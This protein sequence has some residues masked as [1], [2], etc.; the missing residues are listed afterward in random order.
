MDLI[1]NLALGF[2][3]SL[4][5]ENILYAFVGCT[6]GTLIGVLPGIGALATIAM[7]LPVTFGL[8][9][10]SG[11]IMLAGIYYG[12][13]YGGSISAILVNLPGETS[14]VVTTID[15]HQMARRGQAGPALAAAALASFFAGTV[16]T[17]V[18]A[19]FAAPLASIAFEFGPA[20][21]F[22]LMVVGLIGAVVLA[23]GPLLKA[24]A[25]IVLGLLLGLVGTD[26]NTGVA[27]FDMRIPE[28][29]EGLDVVALA[30]GL[31]AIP[32]IIVNLE[33]REVRESI[34]VRLRNLWPS[35]TQ[36]R[37][38]VP[39]VLRGTTLGSLLGILP[40]GAASVA[41]FASYTLEK[42]T[43]RYREEFGKGAIEGV[44]GPEAANNAAAQTTFIPL[45][46]L[47]LP[48]NAVMALMMGAMI[49]HNI[50]PSPLVMTKEPALFWGLI[51]SMW[52]GNLILVILNLPLVGVWVQLLK[53]QYKYL[54]PAI[55]VFCCIG[56]Y[57]VGTTSFDIYQT[58][59][60]GV[61][62]YVLLKLGC[63]PAPLLLGFVL[64][65][66][67]EESFRRALLISRGNYVT[68]V[69]SPIS[70]AL[71]AIAAVLALTVAL[72]AIKRV[73]KTAFS[74]E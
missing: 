53:V 70:L 73:R 56:A 20:E 62:G 48:S 35:G 52:V 29:A 59:V 44:A 16:A 54:S 10:I 22:S 66:M 36:L 68:F 58:A 51:T 64:G 39:S 63:E 50:Q 57:T 2:S 25:M 27:R 37:R 6:F 1:S 46:T 21:N 3:N 60:F 74:E 42:Q 34:R 19:T 11:L 13:Q 49:V 4:T 65:P 71:L 9:P 69:D 45:L 47:G 30:M 18:I 33:K 26:I 28:L 72:P 67:M 15:G 43:S 40:G 41:S 24:V 8:P 14:S 5:L 23:S 61:M 7:L 55:L 32:E 31:F 12:A 38:M 17:L